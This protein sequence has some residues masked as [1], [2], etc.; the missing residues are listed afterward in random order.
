MLLGLLNIICIYCAESFFRQMPMCEE[1][2]SIMNVKNV[3]V[4]TVK[5]TQ[6]FF[7]SSPFRKITHPPYPRT[8]LHQSSIR[9]MKEKL[10]E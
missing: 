2:K 1:N 9:K 7:N 8:Y 10:T 5:V 4:D 6:G 3:S